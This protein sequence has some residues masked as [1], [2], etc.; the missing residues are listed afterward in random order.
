MREGFHQCVELFLFGIAQNVVEI[1]VE[2][3][4]I[5]VGGYKAGEVG[6]V[7]LLVNMEQ[8]LQVV[9]H[10]GKPIAADGI[11]QFRVEVV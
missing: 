11:L 7:V 8:L 1:E 4:Q 6:V 3:L 2:K 5:K 10:N 9:W